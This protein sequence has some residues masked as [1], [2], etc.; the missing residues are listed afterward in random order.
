MQLL[1]A[2]LKGGVV[3]ID[4]EPASDVKFLCGGETD[5]VGRVLI[6]ESES[7]YIVDTQPDLMLVIEQMKGICDQ[8]VTVGNHS[9]VVGAMGQVN[10]QPLLSVAN[11]AESI[12]NYLDGFKP[13]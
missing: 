6:T 7:I 8:L 1:L 10:G 9:Y 4:G 11:S 5:S 3:Y 2:E 13:V 12:K